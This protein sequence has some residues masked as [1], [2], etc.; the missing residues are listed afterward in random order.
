MTHAWLVILLVAAVLNVGIA[1]A[2]AGVQNALLNANLRNPGS[3]VSQVQFFVFSSGLGDRVKDA[4][5]NN[6]PIPITVSS[7]LGQPDRFAAIGGGQAGLDVS[8]VGQDMVKVTLTPTKVWIATENVQFNMVVTRANSVRILSTQFGAQPPIWFNAATPPTAIRPAP[9]L[10][11]FTISTVAD[12]EFT[13][14]NDLADA[15]RI[16]NLLFL[17]SITQS[18][19]DALDL[20]ALLAAAF[21]SSLPS[22]V[23]SASTLTDFPRLPD[24]DP[25][26]LFAAEF[27]LLDPVDGVV[28][29]AFATGIQPVPEPGA[30]SLMLV[31]LATGAVV[32]RVRRR[33]T[34]PR[35]RS[36]R[37]GGCARTRSSPA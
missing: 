33:A 15:F 7:P 26:N 31:G 10:P 16:Q 27:Q 19:F 3:A 35:A 12:A 21:D 2:H 22:F 14:F 34:P 6:K 8:F 23:M 9:R 1:P 25:G 13:L 17:P 5:Q 18:A 4:L 30:V 24:P 32:L 28:V 37:F 20:E 36:S 29:G 11:G